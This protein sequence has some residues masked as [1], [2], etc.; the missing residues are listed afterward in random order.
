MMGQVKDWAET[1]VDGSF[2]PKAFWTPDFKMMVTGG[3][4]GPMGTTPTAL[5]CEAIEG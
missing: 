2:E 5:R 3:E 1:S 4:G